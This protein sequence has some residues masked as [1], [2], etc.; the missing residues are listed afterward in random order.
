MNFK[1]SIGQEVYHKLWRKNATISRRM[2]IEDCTEVYNAYDI[3]FNTDD[4]A[5]KSLDQTTEFWLE[6]KRDYVE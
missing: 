6:E 5:L 4:G 1:F 3:A 2:I